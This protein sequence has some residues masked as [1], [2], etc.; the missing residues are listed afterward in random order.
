VD[1][2][3]LKVVGWWRTG[4]THVQRG[5]PA[6]GLQ[7]CEEAL[8]LS[9]IPFDA[10]AIQGVRGRGLVNVGQVVRGIADLTAAV[11]WFDQ[12]HLRYTHAF[13]AL[14]LAE[15]YL[16]QGEVFQTRTI[17]EEVLSTSQEA[18][19]RH[20]AGVAERYLGEALMTEEPVAAA[21]HL[22]VALHILEEVGARNEVAKTLVAQAN[23][24][25]TVG[26]VSEARY[27][28]ARALALFET[29]GT[30]DEPHRVE[31]LLA[32]LEDNR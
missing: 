12:L 6:H 23:L 28:L 15:A 10:A 32:M 3:R 24:H 21:G 17:C 8:V 9:P 19:Y 29:L 7:C 1:D 22:E 14:W 20:L 13:F 31:A 25:R 27:L 18:G 26:D 5:D 11:T 2:L 30:L 4:S 16:C